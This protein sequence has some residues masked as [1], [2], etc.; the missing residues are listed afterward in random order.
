MRPYVDAEII[1]RQKRVALLDAISQTTNGHANF[2]LITNDPKVEI[3]YNKLINPPK[4]G[5]IYY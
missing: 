2:I 4:S 5:T 1:E 3:A